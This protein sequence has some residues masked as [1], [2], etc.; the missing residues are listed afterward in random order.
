MP[1]GKTKNTPSR[2]K[3][4]DEL[5]WED[6]RFNRNSLGEAIGQLDNRVYNDKHHTA[7][8]YRI[9]AKTGATLDDLASILNIRKETL[10]GW[11]RKHKRFARAVV[12]GRDRYNSDEVEVK[13]LKRAR[14]YTETVVEETTK[15]RPVINKGEVVLDDNGNVLTYEEKIT[16]RKDIVFPP[17]VRAITF[18]LTNRNR[19]R[20]SRAPNPAKSVKN[21]YT[22]I[23][24]S[25]LSVE[26]LQKLKQLSEKAGTGKRMGSHI[27][28]EDHVEAAEFQE[29]TDA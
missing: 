21:E 10:N 7:L 16:L 19:K 23:N 14:G 12:L 11:M 4:K 18:F 17:D 9:V 13:L 26:E 29:T 24:L 2:K 5:E 15:T 6:V 25:T 8:A 28:P 1:R 20:W 22:Q 27:S 3:T